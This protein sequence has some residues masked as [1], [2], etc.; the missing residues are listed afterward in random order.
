MPDEQ[1]V[2]RE[3]EALVHST[4]LAVARL[5]EGLRLA[6]LRLEEAQSEARLAAECVAALA[7]GRAIARARQRID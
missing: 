5:T 7:A 2:L 6:L 3:T 4:A 1:I